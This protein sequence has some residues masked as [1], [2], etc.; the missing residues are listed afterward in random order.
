MSAV[1]RDPEAPFSLP[2]NA[3]QAHKFLHAI[4]AHANIVGQ[5]PSPY[6]RPTIA[7]SATGMRCSD[8][9]QKSFIT[10]VT[11][12]SGIDLAGLMLVEACDTHAQ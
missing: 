2:D 7:T 9:N 3:V 12:C 5:Q 8:M 6:P 10:E 1:G 4:L 11:G